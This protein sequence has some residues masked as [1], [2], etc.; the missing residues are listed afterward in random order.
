MKLESDADRVL[1]T[2]LKE[3]PAR[4]A[5][6]AK[7][8]TLVIVAGGMAAG[9]SAMARR[10]IRDELPDA[11][12]ID[13]DQF[14]L[15]SPEYWALLPSDPEN[16]YGRSYEQASLAAKEAMAEAL[17]RRLD[18][19]WEVT[20]AGTAM[21][22]ML[23]WL[24]ELGY[25]ISLCS[26]DCAVEVAVERANKRANDPND[27]IHF[28]RDLNWNPPPSCEPNDFEQLQSLYSEAVARLDG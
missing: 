27:S 4:T 5:S 11:T 14:I 10:L 9:K 15:T 23:G 13:V 26:V 16:A 6:Q 1:D 3:I 2:S 8:P 19:V 24:K 20:L 21:D 17:A 7:Q 22:Q 28:H 25:S 12:L 18:L